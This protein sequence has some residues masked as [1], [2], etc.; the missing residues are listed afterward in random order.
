MFDRTD[1]LRV[2]REIDMRLSQPARLTLIGGS[3]I[4]LVY[5][6]YCQTRDIDYVE[7]DA[8]VR[9]AIASLAREQPDL[10]F[11]AVTIFTAPD[12]FWDRLEPL[13]FP[14]LR[15]LVVDVP[16]RHDLAVMKIARGFDRD[17][18]AVVA[19][20][21]VE[22]FDPRTLVARFAHKWGPESGAP[23]TE[24]EMDASFHTALTAF[25]GER[26]ANRG[27]KL[28]GL[29]RGQTS[30]GGRRPRR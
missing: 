1:L 9:S 8:D 10:I 12:G 26:V 16:E 29:E 7:A 4:A 6:P 21:A 11:T 28:L 13:D 15:H 27:M 2:L 24:A 17:L 14:L 30:R 3:A 5:E 25:F 20:H 23:G 18:E 22:P 19:M